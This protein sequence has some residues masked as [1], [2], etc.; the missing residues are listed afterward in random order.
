MPRHPKRAQGRGTEPKLAEEGGP[1][2]MIQK[3]SET[4]T[5]GYGEMS[6]WHRSMNWCHGFEDLQVWLE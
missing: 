2:V 1:G 5:A 6:R 4:G 3:P